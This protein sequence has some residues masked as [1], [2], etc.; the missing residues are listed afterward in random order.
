MD[1]LLSLIHNPSALIRRLS[2]PHQS[3]CIDIC[4]RLCLKGTFSL[5]G[6][7][8][9]WNYVLVMREDTPYQLVIAI[10]IQWGT[11]LC[12]CFGTFRHIAPQ[13]PN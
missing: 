8:F 7:I 4:S 3:Q 12:E 5:Y 1:P 13:L 6:H 10:K 9:P 11:K 2:L